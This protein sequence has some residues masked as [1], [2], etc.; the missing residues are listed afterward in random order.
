MRIFSII[1][2][3][4]GALGNAFSIFQTDL[5]TS[6]TASAPNQT[7]IFTSSDSTVKITGNSSTNTINLQAT[8]GAAGFTPNTSSIT[9]ANSPYT[10]LSTDNMVKANATGGNIVV[11]T[12]TPANKQIFSVVKSDATA[13][14]I[15]ISGNLIGP[16]TVTLSNQGDAFSVWSD[17]SSWYPFG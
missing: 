1:A 8:T 16:A 4:A 6:P 14:T 11:T 10:G 3:A 9:F 2:S 12:P 17:G 5:G 13:N 15:A 7:L